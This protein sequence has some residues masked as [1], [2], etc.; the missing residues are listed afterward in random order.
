NFSWEAATGKLWPEVGQPATELLYQ[1]S[2]PA[3]LG[4]NDLELDR[5]LLGKTRVIRFS[6]VGRKLL[7]IA[8]NYDYRAS[9]SNVSEQQAVEKSFAQSV[10]WGFTIEAETGS[11]VLVDAT[12]FL[13]RDV[14][15]AANRIKA[16]DQGSYTF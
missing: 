5:G 11:S 2:L 4:S 12:D 7:M 1:Q 8:L 6:R 15:N 14:M 16:K 10:L 9:A 13:V 3:G